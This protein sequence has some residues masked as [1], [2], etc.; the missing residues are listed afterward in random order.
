[1]AF[2]PVWLELVAGLV[3][4]VALGPVAVVERLV[5]LV[6]LVHRVAL[7]LVDGV[8]LAIRLLVAFRVIGGGAVLLGH[9]L[10][11][12]RVHGLALL[13]GYLLAL[14]PVL[15]L[16]LRVGHVL[17]RLHLKGVTG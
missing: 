14:G 6:L 12:L 11:L 13:L 15:P 3:D 4:E 16:A 17:A 7:L 10:A 9:L 2:S 8:A 5:G 1:M